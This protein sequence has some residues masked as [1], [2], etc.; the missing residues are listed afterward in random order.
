[1]DDV[2]PQRSTVP[3]PFS[4]DFGQAPASLVGRDDLLAD[5]ETGLATGPAD[6][7]FTSV[8]L[9]VRG[10]GKTVALS[11][12]ENR[13]KPNGWVILSV[14][15]S[16]PGILG[17][18]SNAI[19]QVSRD[20]ESLGLGGSNTRKS[21]ERSSEITLGP[22][23][24]KWSEQ[25]FFDPN[26][27]MGLLERLTMLARTVQQFDTS[28]LLTVDELHAA[29]REEARRLAN[30]LQM[31]TKR[32]Q[33]PLA[34]VGAGLLEMK[35]TLLEDKRNTFFRRCN[36]YEMPP[37]TH[38]EA[39]KGLRF[40]IEDAGG[41][42]T[43]EALTL[44]ASAVGDLP[45]TLQVIGH[46][47]WTVAD[48]P[49]RVIDEYAV[50]QAISI[51]EQVVDEN[52]SESAFYELSDRE[53]EFLIE[54]AALDGTGSAVAITR[55]MGL[56][57]REGRK[58]SR[59]LT[60]SGYVNKN[61]RGIVTLTNLVP[62]RVIPQDHLFEHTYTQAPNVVLDADISHPRV[63]H[64]CRKWMPRAKARCVLPPNHRGG[65]RSKL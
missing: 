36:K 10:T 23:K 25:E 49:N 15:A 50:E 61:D 6:I 40:P 60:L 59:R 65:C 24:G 44:G 37:L 56:N 55:Q 35:Y 7:R 46:T 19:T 63:E 9:G 5:I 29:D 53:Q 28:V 31:I 41:Q 14:D 1:M 12:I 45:Y 30:D 43:R 16:T 34:F 39:I 62:V 51:A 22:Y 57:D 48:A 17:R 54:L 27:D 47:A 2:S 8:L 4:P 20:Y 32:Q 11:E 38:P 33:L 52:I 26:I 64:L 58:I 42:I 21:K 13:V 3:N 18:I